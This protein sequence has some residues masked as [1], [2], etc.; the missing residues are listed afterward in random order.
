MNPQNDLCHA[1]FS[2]RIVSNSRLLILFCHDAN[3]GAPHSGIPD[4]VS[5]CHSFSRHSTSRRFC[6]SVHLV[7]SPVYFRGYPLR[8]RARAW[9]YGSDHL[10]FPDHFRWWTLARLNYDFD[11][12]RYTRAGR[13]SRG[14][15]G[16][17][18]GRASRGMNG[19]GCSMSS[20]SFPHRRRS[21]RSSSYVIGIVVNAS[22]APR[23]GNRSRRLSRRSHR[24]SNH[25]PR[26]VSTG[27]PVTGRSR[28]S[29]RLCL[30][31]RLSQWCAS[32]PVWTRG[33]PPPPARLR[34][35]PRFRS[36]GRAVDG[37]HR[38][39]PRGAPRAASEVWNF[40]ALYTWTLDGQWV[41][42]GHAGTFLHN[43][44][45]DPRPA[46]PTV[47]SFKCGEV[48]EWGRVVHGLRVTSENRHSTPVC[49]CEDHR[50]SDQGF[51]LGN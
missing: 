20:F 30:P 25:G 47:H 4:A 35:G 33:T 14:W 7:T 17:V 5:M 38:V 3:A 13:S 45:L 48:G 9:Y 40:T 27:R 37:W 50:G 41:C 21:A 23:L 12:W 51:G 32:N 15:S 36:T 16:Q 46:P 1:D 49:T 26:S 39:R 42:P 11:H 2:Y 31:T 44:S 22:R 8:H 19:S 28:P 34:G 18:A 6:G 43:R 29:A 24:L 10:F